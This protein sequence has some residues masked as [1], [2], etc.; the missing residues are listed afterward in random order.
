MVQVQ[1]LQ[2]VEVIHFNCNFSHANLC[3]YFCLD[4]WVSKIVSPMSIYGGGAWDHAPPV[5]R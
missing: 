4:V 1:V 5:Q 3:V 2:L